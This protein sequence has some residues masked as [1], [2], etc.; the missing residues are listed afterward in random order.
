ML[1]LLLQPLVE[2]ALYHGLR[3]KRGRGLITVSAK[4]DIDGMTFRVSDTGVGMTPERLESVNAAMRGS[5]PPGDGRSGFGL[6]NV[7]RRLEL[8][9]GAECG[10]RIESGAGG[11]AVSFRLP[12]S[13]PQTPRR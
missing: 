13:P 8:Y 3:P 4:A 7:N 9:Y 5:A 10:L 11:S 2:N 1:K 12:K 6:F